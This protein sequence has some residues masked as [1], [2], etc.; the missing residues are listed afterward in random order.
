MRELHQTHE[1]S[2]EIQNKINRELQTQNARSPS[3]SCE[4]SFR[5]MRELHQSQLNLNSQHPNR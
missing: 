5:I 1:N 4:Y 3:E 2:I